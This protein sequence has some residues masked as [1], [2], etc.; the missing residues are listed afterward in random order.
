M[1]LL[2]PFICAFLLPLSY[3]PLLAHTTARSSM[4][5]Q[6][7]AILAQDTIS[8]STKL[9]FDKQVIKGKLKNGFTYY[10]LKNVEPEKRVTM[11]LANKVGSILE[12][13]NERGLAHFLEHMQFNGLKHFPKNDLVNYLQKAGVRFG[14]DLNA[15]T[16]FEET[17]YQLPIPSDDPE[18]LKNGLQV[19]RDWAQD[20]L[21]T[22]E[23]IDKERGVVLEEM[24]GGRGA[25]KR[26]QDQYFPML[27]NQSLYSN[28]LPIGTEDIIT[29]F[30][31]N[32]LRDFH[33]RWY[34]PDLQALI[35]VGDI[36]VAEMESEV[37][38]LFSDLKK[39]KDYVL[40]KEEEIPLNGKNQFL[41]VTDPEMP[42][43]VG[44]LFF[45]YRGN[46]PETVGDYRDALLKNAFNNLINLR[47]SD[48]TEK[49]DAPFIQGSVNFSSLLKDIRTL[50]LTYVA[51]P[52]AIEQG[53]KALLIEVERVKRDG[54]TQAELDRVIKSL[55]KSNETSFIERDKR[56]SDRY[57][58]GYLS[59][60]LKQ[61]PSLGME[62]N[63]AIT[64][65]LLPSLTLKEINALLTSYYTPQ[66]RDILFL[67]AE[68]EKANLPDEGTVNKWIS[69]VAKTPITAYADQVSDL[70]LLAQLPASGTVVSETETASIGTKTLTL[71]NGAK[72]VLKP[73][74]FKNDEI[75][76][77][78]VSAGGTSLYSDADYFSAKHAASLVSSSGS[79]QLNSK[80]LLRYWAGKT[81]AAAPYISE[82]SEGINARSDQEGLKDVFEL[83][84][85]YFTAPRLDQDIFENY[86]SRSKASLEN[87]LSNPQAVF[88][89]AINKSLYQGN[90]RRLSDTEAQ[91]NQIQKDRSLAI[92]KERFADASDF[93]FTIVGSFTEAQIKP[94][95][96]QYIASLPTLG[97]KEVG[98]DLGI[99]APKQGLTEK[100]YKG[101][102]EKANVVMYYIGD[103]NYN[104]ADNLAM[105]ALAS[106]LSYKLLERLREDEGGVYGVGAN[107]SYSKLPVGRYQAAIGFGTAIDKV[108]SLINSVHEEVAKIIA[109]G[110]EQKDL[111]KYFIEERRQLEL[112]LKENSFWLNQLNSSVINSED[113]TAILTYEKELLKVDAASIQRAAKR[114]LKEDQLFKFILLPEN[115]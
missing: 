10:I 36:D 52:G 108:E 66:N 100:V 20:A 89:D 5:V 54:F 73:T 48:L 90:I 60:F 114:Y 58:Q 57:V 72:V 13:E 16:S 74:K 40:P 21:L 99:R 33:T 31:P 34:R 9:P 7:R 112:S 26:M 30:Q 47:F 113:P 109:H 11:Y 62:E 91:M 77:A 67:S 94:F 59:N 23:E 79:G 37:K 24:R 35:I 55:Q 106:V 61:E 53:F 103:Y 92:F 83:I 104:R 111:D 2:K 110:P 43:V 84:Y 56:K 71:S 1:R 96:T 42:Y 75:R 14:S 15:Y 82:L 115:K 6:A 38:R 25:S 29:N 49:A 41:T 63:Y 87:R 28:R 88:S 64:K 81:A 101:K 80:E 105:D 22:T 65:Q 86:I 93:T 8:W 17:V 12:N 46:V 39:P 85:S 3:S 68:K 19:M 97:R 78:A 51:K 70:P 32:V 69:E 95:L 107:I 27:F 45:K 76:I 50:Q 102:E 98:K 44:Q 18:L 4:H